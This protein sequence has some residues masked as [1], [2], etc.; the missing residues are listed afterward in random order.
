MEPQPMLPQTGSALLGGLTLAQQPT[1]TY[2][3][4]RHARFF[5]FVDGAEAMRQAIYL[6][7]SIERYAYV[8]YSWRYG[9]ELSD[10]F[11]KDTTFVLPELKRR[12]REALMQDTRITDVYGFSFSVDQGNVHCKFHAAT[13]FG[14]VEIEKEFML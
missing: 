9:I 10:L 2:A 5:G 8:I 1:N 7:L 13:V 6:I 14:P 11:G 3:M 12:I 4:Q